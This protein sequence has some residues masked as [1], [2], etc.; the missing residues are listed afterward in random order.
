MTKMQR[1]EAI[2]TTTSTELITMKV[3][4]SQTV[5][6]RRFRMSISTKQPPTRMV[7]L[8]DRAMVNQ[9]AK[10][11]SFLGQ[12]DTIMGIYHHLK[13]AELVLEQSPILPEASMQKP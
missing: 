4:K 10:A 3:M 12:E 2:Y 13:E 11:T 1:L 6:T 8:W 5:I 9:M 7:K